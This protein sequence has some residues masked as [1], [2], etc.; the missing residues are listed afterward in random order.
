MVTRP[1]LAIFVGGKSRRM[2]EHKGLLPV[3]GGAE[4]ILEALV[5]RGREAGFDPLLVGEATPYAHL[6]EGVTRIEDDPVGVGPLAGLQAAL[7]HALST[8]R[9][10]VVTVACDMPYV[11]AEALQQLRDHRSEAA[12]VAPRRGPNAPWEP[13]LASYDAARLANTL[14]EAISQGQRSFQKLFASVE[15]EALPLTPAMDRALQDWD[16]PED[17]AR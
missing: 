5:R 4:P 1:L 6:A 8:G 16:T 13:M 2:G 7:R 14:A 9:S 3:P 17:V 15:I 11:T 12:I 10:R